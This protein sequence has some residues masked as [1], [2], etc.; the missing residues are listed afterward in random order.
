MRL[1]L[2]EQGVT[3]LM[4]AVDHASGLTKLAAGLRLAPDVPEAAGG[5]R[6]S[7]GLLRPVR[8]EEAEGRVGAIF[9]EIR[10]W[11]GEHLGIDRVPG[12]WLA[13]GH[14]PVYLDAVWRREQALMGEGAV[15]RLQKLC[16]GF[17]LAANTVSPYMVDY[18]AA[19][20]RRLGLDEHGFLEVL[21]VVDY[22]NNLNTLAAGM[23]IESDI[24]PGGVD[25]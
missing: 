19:G 25:R 16:V 6:G 9:R 5:T 2:D 21:A 10:A 18:Y 12:L 20:L 7:P 22:F 17:A 8:E 15:S 24:K 14:H 13:L 4:A 11:A 3:E 23:D 1:G